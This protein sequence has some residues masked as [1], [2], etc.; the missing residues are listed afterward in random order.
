M[1]LIFVSGPYR[2]PEGPNGVFKNIAHARG[3]AREL[4]LAGWA[5]FCPHMNSAFMDGPDFDNPA[6]YDGDLRIL[7]FCDAIF[8]LKDWRSSVGAMGEYQFAY[9]HDK[10]VYEE[11]DGIIPSPED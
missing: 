3:I 8:M 6:F 1:K 5:V 10:T 9:D 7:E 2:S 11:I 4:W